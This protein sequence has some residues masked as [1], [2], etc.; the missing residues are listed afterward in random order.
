MYNSFCMGDTVA[1]ATLCWPLDEI[2]RSTRRSVIKCLNVYSIAV[3]VHEY[4][5]LPV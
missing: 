4:L 2:M 1:F 3:R 5:L